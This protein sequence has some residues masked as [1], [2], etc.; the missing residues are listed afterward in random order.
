MPFE[1]ARSLLEQAT[2]AAV[3]QPEMAATAAQQSLAAFERLGT[4]RYAER[5]RRLLRGLGISPPRT[6][7]ARASVATLSARE[8]EVARLVAEGLTRAEIAERLVLSPR[9]ID[10]HLEHMYVR[11]GINSRAVLARYVTEAGLLSPTR[12]R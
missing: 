1:A 4:L 5:S 8:L 9:T 10:H 3:L 6:R 11:L 12:E 2:A 7:R